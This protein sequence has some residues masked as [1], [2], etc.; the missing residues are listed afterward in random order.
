MA[1]VVS[2][3]FEFVRI[4]G[5]WCPYPKELRDKLCEHIP[6]SGRGFC[7]DDFLAWAIEPPDV[8]EVRRIVYALAAV[9]KLP[10]PVGVRAVAPPDFPRETVFI[11]RCKHGRIAQDESAK[12]QKSVGAVQREQSKYRWENLSIGEMRVYDGVTAAALLNNWHSWAKRRRDPETGATLFR[13][14]QITTH[15]LPDGRVEVR[16]TR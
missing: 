2:D 4:S 7:A 8:R 12:V 1:Y 16:R 9:L 10:Y 6:K 15:A 3:G 5:K 11:Y 13:T 14:R